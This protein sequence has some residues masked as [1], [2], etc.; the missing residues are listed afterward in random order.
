[1][2]TTVRKK[3]QFIASLEAVSP[4]LTINNH[5][6]SIVKAKIFRF[7]NLLIRDLRLPITEAPA[8]VRVYELK[9]DSLFSG[10]INKIKI[11]PEETVVAFCR[12][13]QNFLG[14][15]KTTTFFRVSEDVILRVR[16][17]S[18]GLHVSTYKVSD[19]IVWQSRFHHRFVF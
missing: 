6:E 14:T 10:F 15:E 7:G 2:E 5:G 11:V 1:M 3:S 8:V 4:L 13:Y 9:I 18:D 19:N 12:Q 16:K 17:L